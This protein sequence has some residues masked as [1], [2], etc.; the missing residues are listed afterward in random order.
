MHP[1]IIK[2]SE[3]F[4]TTGNGKIDREKTMQRWLGM[5]SDQCG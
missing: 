5:E 1:S 2:E 4:E 3:R